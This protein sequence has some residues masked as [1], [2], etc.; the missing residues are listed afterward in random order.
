[1]GDLDAYIQEDKI[2]P[3]ISGNKS[4]SLKNISKEIDDQN[5]CEVKYFKSF[6][7]RIK[8]YCYIYFF[9]IFI[10]YFIT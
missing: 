3:L 1:M 7:K 5:P 10:N 8:R 4:I 6:I 9:I 2:V